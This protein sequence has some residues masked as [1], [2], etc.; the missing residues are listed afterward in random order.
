VSRTRNWETKEQLKAGASG[1]VFNGAL[2][3]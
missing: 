1:V 3:S 2:K